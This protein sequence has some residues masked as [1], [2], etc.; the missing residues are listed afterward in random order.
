M[1][2]LG[3]QNSVSEFL[4][5]IGEEILEEVGSSPE[6]Q[7][8]LLAALRQNKELIK[9]FVFRA[10]GVIEQRCHRE[11]EMHIGGYRDHLDGSVSLV[12]PRNRS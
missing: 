7:E 3:V 9:G 4:A 6:A 1:S 12:S 8:K 11:S 2:V 5:V 10:F